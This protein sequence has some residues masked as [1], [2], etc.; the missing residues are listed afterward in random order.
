MY[1]DTREI[2]YPQLV[3]A[4]QKAESEQEDQTGE[5]IHVRSIQAEGKDDITRLSE[6]IAQL[7]MVVQ[8]PQNTTIS[9]PQQSGSEKDGSEKR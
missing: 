5:G 6:Q 7:W 4:A 2:T 8:K 3:K 9:N 1:D